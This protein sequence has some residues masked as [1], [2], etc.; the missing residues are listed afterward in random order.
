VPRDDP[1]VG[2]LGE[3]EEA[4]HGRC[5]RVEDRRSARRGGE[6]GSLGEGGQ[7][8]LHWCDGVGEDG[9]AHGGMRA[10]GQPSLVEGLRE[11]CVVRLGES[12]EAHEGVDERGRRGRVNPSAQQRFQGIGHVAVGRDS[13]AEGGAAADLPEEQG[14]VLQHLL[15]RHGSVGV[16]QPGAVDGVRG[17]DRRRQVSGAQADVE[18]VLGDVGRQSETAHIDDRRHAVGQVPIKVAHRLASTKGRGSGGEQRPRGAAVRVSVDESGDHEA[19]S[20][21]H[22]LD[23]SATRELTCESGTDLA[24]DAVG[25]EDVGAGHGGLGTDD[26]SAGDQYVIHVPSL[27]SR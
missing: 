3:L 25:D 14:T 4:G 11:C 18:L 15:G 8:R 1:G 12:G 20:G 7:R 23:I 26:G 10:R 19:T 17:D 9:L 21:V 13:A 5:G 27:S 22:S 16:V 2:G 24:D 6:L